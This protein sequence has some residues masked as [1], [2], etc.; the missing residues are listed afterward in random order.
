MSEHNDGWFKSSRSGQSGQCVE[1][2]FAGEDV[3]VR[4][5][6]DP[7]GPQLKFNR[8]KWSAFTEG[9]NL[10]EFKQP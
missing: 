1:V 9:V 10:G 7:N 6:E 2:R 4:D 5:S 3:Y 8:A